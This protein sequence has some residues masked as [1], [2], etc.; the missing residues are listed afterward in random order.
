MR[1]AAVALAA[2]AATGCMSKTDS[3][4]A[5]ATTGP[6]ADLQIEISIRGSETPTKVWTLHCPPGGT[7]PD[8]ATACSKLAEVKDP[9][10]PVPKGTACT[11]IY[12]G[13]EIAHV[14]GTF[15]GERVDTKFSRGNG[16]E[17]ERW[18]KAAFLFPGIG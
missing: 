14:S 16:C 4:K 1:I 15:N 2:L 12:G 6:T 5:K 7:L 17:L 8:A 9:F 13:P 3:D 10:A 11:Q 18:N